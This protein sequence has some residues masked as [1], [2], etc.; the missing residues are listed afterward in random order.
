M[1]ISGIFELVQPMGRWTAAVFR[2][3]WCVQLGFDGHQRHVSENGSV[4]G[5]GDGVN[6]NGLVDL[7]CIRMDL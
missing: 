4:R 1:E 2:P 7:L 3:V 5:C 6:G